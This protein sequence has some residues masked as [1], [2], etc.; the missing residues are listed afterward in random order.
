V[1]GALHGLAL[2]WD[3][4]S[5]RTRKKIRKKATPTLY[6]FISWSIT[7]I[8]I[9]FTWIFFR[10]ENISQAFH[11]IN[12]TFSGLAQKS[13]YVKTID[14]F[15]YN[16]ID[17]FTI[18]F[19]IFFILLELWGRNQE[20]ALDYI[21]MKWRKPLRYAVYYAITFAILW[22]SGNEQQFLYFNF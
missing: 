9:V 17:Y 2:A 18:I 10:A 7:F 14:L 15:F 21:S 6:N 1:W 12:D 4:V 5:A 20:Y 11:F 19:T 16:R 13:S 22:Y 8:F 3:V